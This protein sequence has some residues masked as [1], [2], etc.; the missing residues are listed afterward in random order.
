MSLSPEIEAWR[1]GQ[2]VLAGT[3]LSECI[4][5]LVSG[6]LVGT[7]RLGQHGKNHKDCLVQYRFPK[8]NKFLSRKMTRPERFI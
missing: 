6:Q 2:A 4:C 8:G 1:A 5:L 3:C 7:A